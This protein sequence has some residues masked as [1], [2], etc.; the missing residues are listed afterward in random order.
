MNE[1]KLRMQE[2][3]K[4]KF[5]KAVTAV[6]ELVRNS[7][8]QVLVVG[9]DGMCASGKTTLGYYLKSLFDCNLFH[10]DDFFLQPWQRTMERLNEVGGNVDYERFKEEV[11]DRVL[12]Q[13]EVEYRP[14]RCM[15]GVIMEGQMIPWKRLTIIEGSYSLHP[16]FGDCYDL[17]IFTQLTKQEQLNRIRKRNGE[18]KL[19]R[20]VKEWIPKEEAYFEKYQI[21]NRCICIG[22]NE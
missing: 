13:Q 6:N 4:K 14:Y 2:S 5:E 1:D 8:K 15:E 16:Y 7:K 22:H 17:H 18:E 11:L 19:T 20:F 21:K 9:I 10:M 12:S 3:C